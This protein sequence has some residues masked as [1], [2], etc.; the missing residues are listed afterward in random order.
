MDVDDLLTRLRKR[1]VDEISCK[2]HAYDQSDPSA[3]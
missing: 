2:V 3:I 1:P